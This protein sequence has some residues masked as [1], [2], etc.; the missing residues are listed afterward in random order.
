M[1]D[2]VIDQSIEPR[3][4]DARHGW[5]WTTH[6]FSLYRQA[7]LQWTAMT[8]LML[9]VLIGMSLIPLLAVI[10]SL[11]APVLMGG[12]MLAARKADQ[13]QPVQ[14]MDLFDGF[15]HR[16]QPLL[17][18]GA[19]YFLATTVVLFLATQIANHYWPINTQALTRSLTEA[20]TQAAPENAF[21]FSMT[22]LGSLMLVYSCYFFAPALVALSGVRPFESMRLS[23]SACVRN[24][25]ALLVLMGVFLALGMLA[26]FT[27]GLA[28]IVIMPIAMLVNYSAFADLFPQE[29]TP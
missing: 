20:A 21:P 5:L 7:P 2:I 26:I 29:T 14:L 11:L 13:G 17:A 8:V 24:W 16:T 10:A 25:S 22:I 6:A 3:R 4:V 19:L 12:M 9:V 1:S 23:V 18:V 27:M 28:F 15:K